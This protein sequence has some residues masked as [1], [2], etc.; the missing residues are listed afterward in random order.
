[1]KRLIT[2]V[3]TSF[4]VCPVTHASD[5]PDDTDKYRIPRFLDEHSEVEEC[6]GQ[7]DI[8]RKSTYL[9]GKCSDGTY[10][11][12]QAGSQFESGGI[13]GQVG[14]A[15]MALNLCGLTTFDPDNWDL[16]ISP[17]TGDGT[18]IWEL[19]RQLKKLF[20]HRACIS[21]ASPRTEISSEGKIRFSYTSRISAVKGSDYTN[22][23]ERRI[24]AGYPSLASLAHPEGG[25][26]HVTLIVGVRDDNGVCQVV[27]NT[28]QS[29]YRTSCTRFSQIAR[30]ILHL[31]NIGKS[32][33]DYIPPP[34]KL[35]PYDPGPWHCGSKK[36]SRGVKC[37]V[38]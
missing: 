22:L 38:P 12:H 37:I 30:S 5:Q 20:K 10:S 29:Q 11:Y 13:C 8:T 35:G 15:N 31:R 18:N 34:I 16:S 17:D 25:P 23:A 24:I 7:D 1:M 28:W 27:H 14:L 36:V 19:Q 33:P 32:N 3:L 9:V 4:L 21:Y 6:T 26:G 2:I